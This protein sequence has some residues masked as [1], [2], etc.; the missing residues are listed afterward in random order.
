MNRIDRIRGFSEDLGQG[1]LFDDGVFYMEDGSEY[2]LKEAL[3]LARA[4]PYNR[5]SFAI[6][7]MVKTVFDGEIIDIQRKIVDQDD[8]GILIDDSELDSL[9]AMYFPS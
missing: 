4:D 9:A 7:H 1:Y 8:T 3:L 6:V 5:K 2:S